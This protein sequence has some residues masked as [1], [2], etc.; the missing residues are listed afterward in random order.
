MPAYVIAE[1]DI[2]DPDQYARY[3]AA[4][5]AAIAEG[6]GRFV[7]RGGDVEVLEGDWRPPRLVVL[8]FDDVEAAQR[9]YDS[10]QYRAVR[11]LREGAGRVNMVLVPGYDP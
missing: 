8:E 4:S 11:A 9:W 3:M 7:V 2:T 5:P 10:A 1:T 6:G